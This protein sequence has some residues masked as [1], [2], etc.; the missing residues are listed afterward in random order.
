[1]NFGEDSIN[2]GT[3]V[4]GNGRSAWFPSTDPERRAVREQLKRILDDPLF[5]HSKRYPVLLRYVT[6]KVLRGETHDLKERTI[7]IEA[8]GRSPDYDTNNDT[9][10]R[11][12][13]GEIRKRL[14]QYYY[15]NRKEELQIE[16]PSGSYKPEFYL[17]TA[18]L[19]RID[20]SAPPAEIRSMQH[21]TGGV[22]AFA[23]K[24]IFFGVIF[25]LLATIALL[26]IF[27][28][29]QSKQR[30]LIDFWKPVTA[31]QQS[32]LMCV[33]DR[34]S[35]NA[36]RIAIGESPVSEPSDGA[37]SDSLLEFM[38]HDAV[39]S[40]ATVNYIM[41][42]DNTIKELHRSTHLSPA[43]TTTL[44][45]LRQGP[46]ILIGFNNSWTARTLEPLRFTFRMEKSGGFI[47]DRKNPNQPPVSLPLNLP[48]SKMTHDY[49]IVARLIDPTYGQPV[50]VLA[51]LGEPGTSACVEMASDPS[52]LADLFRNAP[53]HW[54]R[55]NMEALI[56]T[57]VVN[58]NSGRPH[59]EAAY[60]W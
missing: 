19:P 33:G 38:L 48:F 10:V 17:S 5:A 58:G 4:E 2:Q 31:P 40:L 24:N 53:R 13:A 50:I 27:Y 36:Q 14:A 3:Q 57:E 28:F 45:D 15:E 26:A 25:I 46:T 29:A 6:E 51:G 21:H 56:S 20:S 35:Y 52:L 43:S 44:T 16:L 55:R 22:F 59:V 11:V 49:G 8:F 30:I 9:V 34:A 47:L 41:R 37:L 60:W 39:F 1:V 54:Q 12:T 32:I 18:S 7:G 42:V 23:R